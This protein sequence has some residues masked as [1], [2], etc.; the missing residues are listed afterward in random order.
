MVVCQCCLIAYVSDHWILT[1]FIFAAGRCSCPMLFH[2]PLCS[3]DSN[4][5][6]HPSF[7]RL[8]L[9]CSNRVLL[10]TGG[11]QQY[12]FGAEER[13]RSSTFKNTWRSECEWVMWICGYVDTTR[14]YRS[15][16]DRTRRERET[17]DYILKNLKIGNWWLVLPL[18]VLY[19]HTLSCYLMTS[20]LASSSRIHRQRYNSD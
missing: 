8:R 12:L 13:K 2:I 9:I 6:G 4:S 20:V 7:V 18:A 17:N 5:F 15:D 3:V 1:T 10:C 11:S 16:M 14:K 19:Y